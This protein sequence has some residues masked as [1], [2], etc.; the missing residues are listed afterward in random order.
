M[1]N[2]K[3]YA[4]LIEKG[5]ASALNRIQKKYDVEKG[6]LDEQYLARARQINKETRDAKNSASAGHEIGLQNVRDELLSKGLSR[7]GESVNAVIRSNL[8]KNSDYTR[9]DAE[10]TRAHTENALSRSRELGNLIS[11]RLDSEAALEDSMQ[12]AVR[13]EERYADEMRLKEESNA[14]D[15]RRWEAEQ[16]LKE[17]SLKDDRERWDAENARKN[18]E[19]DRKFLADEKQRSIEN[20]REAEKLA[21]SKEKNSSDD[22]STGNNKISAETKSEVPSQTGGYVPDYSADELVNDIFKSMQR[23]YFPSERARSAAIERSIYQVLNDT[24]LAPS[25]KAEVR[26]YASALGY[27]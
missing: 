26:V 8:A 3:S 15:K 9:L 18:F 22:S 21:I 16:S 20:T 10:A 7:S 5:Y 12:K 6:Y 19:S 4:S 11:K 13:D 14:E 24:S 27:I 1:S 25:F 17:A 2:V 23:E